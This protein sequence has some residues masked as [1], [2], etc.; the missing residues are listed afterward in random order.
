MNHIKS[1]HVIQKK[2]PAFKKFQ[3]LQDKSPS[4][5]SNAERILEHSLI[6][7]SPRA[8][9]AARVQAE[10]K[11]MRKHGSPSTTAEVQARYNFTENAAKKLLRAV[12]RALRKPVNPDTKRLAKKRTV[13]SKTAAA[14]AQVNVPDVLNTPVTTVQVQLVAVLEDIRR[15]F[16]EELRTKGE[17]TSVKEGFVYLVTHPSF[18]GWVKAGMTID[19][20]VRLAAYNV[21]DPLSR[22]EL[23]AAKWVADRRNAEKKLLERLTTQAKEI[24]G[25]WARIGLTEAIK[26][27]DML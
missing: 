9:Q 22:F 17:Q 14:V 20:E 11:L 21:A 4:Y 27:F 26:V 24:R 7:A 23:T 19:Y 2:R 25:E 10:I 5:E 6:H 16:T 1:A 8:L 12:E 3:K 13:L 18:Q 15:R